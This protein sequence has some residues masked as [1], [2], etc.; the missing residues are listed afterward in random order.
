M[1]V[2]PLG[3]ETTLA[4][5]HLDAVVLAVGNVDPAVLIAT[6]VVDDVELAW[7]RARFAPREQQPAVRRIFVNPSVAVAVGDV[8]VAARR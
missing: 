7:L 6:D 5:E 4:V 3:L 1:H 8:Q 2:I